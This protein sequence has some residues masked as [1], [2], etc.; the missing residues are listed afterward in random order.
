MT[1]GRSNLFK[2]LICMLLVVLTASS[3]FGC[4][5]TK[6]YKINVIDSLG[7]KIG[8]DE[9]P[10]NVVVLEESLTHMWYLSGGIIKGTSSDYNELNRIDIENK[11]LNGEITIVGTTHNPATNLILSCK[12]DLIIYTSKR[13]TQVN[14]CNSFKEEG[15]KCFCADIDCF[16]DYLDILKQF[17]ILNNTIN[18][19]YVTYGT[20][21]KEEI[22][23]IIKKVPTTSSPKIMFMRGRANGY[24]IYS[25]GSFVCSMLDDLNCINVGVD[26]NGNKVKLDQA[27]QLNYVVDKHPEYCFITYMGASTQAKLDTINNNLDEQIFNTTYWDITGMKDNCSVIKLENRLYFQYKPNDKWAEAY[28]YLYNV[29]Y[30]NEE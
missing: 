10:K 27:V 20:N 9:S 8:F 5:T 4:S 22:D 16:D 12:P 17:C 23:D 24:D 21:V 14:I 7:N 30:N 6:E 15:Y 29:L 28:Q 18:S 26:P 3:I 1:K 25:S 13:A 19:S 11:V 2:K